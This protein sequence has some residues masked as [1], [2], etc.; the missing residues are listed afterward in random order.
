MLEYL[1]FN[2]LMLLRLVASVVLGGLIGLERGIRH[3]AGLRTHILVCLGAA[4]VMV[5]SECL[6][7]EYGISNEIMRMG[8]QVISGVGFLGAG[9]IIMDGNRVRGI[10]TAA[11]LWSTA[12]LGIVVGSGYYLIA[13]F[14]VI[15]MLFTMRWLRSVTQK[16]QEKSLF[17]DIRIT[18]ENRAALQHVLKSLSGENY[19]VSALKVS[20]KK[21]EKTVS[22]ILRIK[23]PQSDMGEGLILSLSEYDG[24]L[25]LEWE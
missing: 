10:T 16:F 8:A 22:A 17:R 7:L 9:S 2:S 18:T 24:V 1:Q 6:V 20:D 13:L 12:C 11:G 3:D 23:M 4:S 14:I 25:E 15:L 21:A 5:I 19:E